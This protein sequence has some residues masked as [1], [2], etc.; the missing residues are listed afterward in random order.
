MNRLFGDHTFIVGFAHVVGPGCDDV[1]HTLNV[2]PSSLAFEPD[3]SSTGF[4]FGRPLLSDQGSEDES[5]H[6]V[7]TFYYLLAW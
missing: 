3:M 4:P 5:P 7:L 2:W 1:S 6:Q